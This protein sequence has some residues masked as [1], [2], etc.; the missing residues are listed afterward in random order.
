MVGLGKD[1]KVIHG[2][3]PIQEIDTVIMVETKSE[4]DKD[5]IAMTGKIIEQDLD[6]AQV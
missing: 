2:T 5:P 1:A 4:V 3:D 6:Q